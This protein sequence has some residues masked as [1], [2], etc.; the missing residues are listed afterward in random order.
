MK[1]KLTI[2]EQIEKIK[3]QIEVLSEECA[4][5]I[6]EVLAGSK[7]RVV[8]FSQQE[9]IDKIIEDNTKKTAKLIVDLE[10]LEEEKKHGH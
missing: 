8:S 9:K 5:K 7:S 2:D 4:V 3:Q 10:E 1:G 6:D